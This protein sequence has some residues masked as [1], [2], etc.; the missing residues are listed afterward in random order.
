MPS[1]RHCNSSGFTLLEVILVLVLMSIFAT[2]AV[3]RQHISD[4]SV[5][6]A[7]EVLKSH[8]RYAQ[9]RSMNTSTPWGIHYDNGTNAYWLFRQ[10]SGERRTLPGETRD[11]V[12]LAAD[13]VAITQ[14][15]F[16]LSF[17]TWGEPTI[18]DAQFQFQQRKAVITLAKG[19]DTRDIT[20]TA[21]TGFLQ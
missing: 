5:Q 9:M 6:A 20:I 4:V 18:S 1:K 11:S 2:I 8:I 15:T 14:G 12:D 19:A 10:T 13:G 21:N 3:S 16:T 17:D 7:S